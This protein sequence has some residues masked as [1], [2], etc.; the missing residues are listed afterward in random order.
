MTAIQSA[1]GRLSSSKSAIILLVRFSKEEITSNSP[2]IL[3][4]CFFIKV[5]NNLL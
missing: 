2:L 1:T 4:V 5:V 3:P